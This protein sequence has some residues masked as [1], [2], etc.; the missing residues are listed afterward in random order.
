LPPDHLY[1][2]D[3][4]ALSGNF[5]VRPA[6]MATVMFDSTT[7]TAVCSSRSA[8]ANAISDIGYLVGPTSQA[9]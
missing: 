8:M 4:R 9:T 6:L 7:V 3:E 1:Q 5:Y 2:K